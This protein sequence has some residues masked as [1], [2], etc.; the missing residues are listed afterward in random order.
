MRV[1]TREYC[2]KVISRVPSRENLPL[3]L[4]ISCFKP[5]LA[6]FE[7]PNL[8]SRQ[9]LLPNVQFYSPWYPVYEDIFRFLKNQSPSKI[10]QA[11]SFHLLHDGRNSNSRPC[12]VSAII[13]ISRPPSSPPGVPPGMGREMDIFARLSP[14][15]TLQFF[16]SFLH[17]SKHS[18]IIRAISN[19]QITLLMF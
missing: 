18:R 10:N 1:D 11:D 17:I 9:I 14:A 2:S 12:R 8:P 3:G 5:L 15:L 7:F 4:S 13:Q 16:L 19:S 6:G